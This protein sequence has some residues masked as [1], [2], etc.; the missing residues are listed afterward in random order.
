M[1]KKKI[2]GICAVIF[3]S[4]FLTGCVTSNPFFSKSQEREAQ[5]QYLWEREQREYERRR[6]QFEMN[7]ESDL[8]D[9]TYYLVNY[10]YENLGKG[11]T[12]THNFSVH[13]IV[14][15]YQ[16]GK[17]RVP[18]TV[19]WMRKKDKE[20][21]ISGNLYYQEDGKAVFYCTGATGTRDRDYQF[22]REIS[23]GIIIL[24]E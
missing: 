17:A 23:E 3:A 20:V 22:V 21:V 15:D 14:Y 2:F 11:S 1:D 18:I 13:R 6:Q 24:S 19:R 4:F 5:K 16:G 7:V 12:P 9:A 10:L 8:S